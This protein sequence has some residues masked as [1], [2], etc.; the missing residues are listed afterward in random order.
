MPWAFPPKSVTTPGG[1]SSS[2][3][4]EIPEIGQAQ[5]G[6]VHPLYSD[7]GEDGIGLSQRYMRGAGY[8]EALKALDLFLQ[9]AGAG[10]ISV[11]EFV[12][13]VQVKLG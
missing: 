12:A 10:I 13:P 8:P 1:K 7:L 9:V 4:E 6:Q 2:R 11:G 5:M 3:L